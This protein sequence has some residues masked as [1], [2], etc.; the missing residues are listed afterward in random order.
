MFHVVKADAEVQLSRELLTRWAES[1]L[2][3]NHLGTLIE[4]EIEGCD[5]GE[6]ALDLAERARRRAWDLFNEL[7]EHGARK[8]DGYQEPENSAAAPHAQP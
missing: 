3:M 1:C 7:V 8:P 2:R 5:G 6:R 4:R